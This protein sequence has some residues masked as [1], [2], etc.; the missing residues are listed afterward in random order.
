MTQILWQLKQT[1]GRLWVRASLFCAIAI[2][3]A[4]LAVYFKDYIPDDFSQKI[5]AD[6]VDGIL[7]IIAS[8]MLAVTTFSLS[9]MVAAYSAATTNVTPRATRLLLQDRTSQNSLSTFIGAFIFALV[10]IVALK[11][12]VY[13][14]SGRLI[15]FVVTIL[16]IAFI[17]LTLIR[18]IEY[19]SRLGRVSETIN[20]IERVATKATLDRIAN[21]YLGGKCLKGS[22]PDTATPLYL[23]KIGYLQLI[24]MQ[25]LQNIATNEGGHIYI[26]FLPGSFVTPDRPAAYLD[27]VDLEKH[28]DRLLGAFVVADDRSFDQDPRFGMIV[29]SEIASR[30]LSPAINDPGT[31]IEIIGTSVRILSLWCTKE[32]PD[33]YEIRYDRIYVPPITARD[34]FEDIYQPIARDGAA[35]M[36]VN[37]RLQKA[38]HSLYAI[39]DEDFKGACLDL[40]D[41]ALAKAKAAV[42]VEEDYKTLEKIVGSLRG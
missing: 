2:A 19:L 20:L 33:D 7:N 35:M 40:S 11:M 38:L 29:L 23:K 15:L 4:L 10:G 13:G 16:V 41:R 5:G 42:S 27:G 24:D 22:A 36:E 26:D 14:D 18:W 8:S 31:A 12:G 30:A 34:L 25:A 37:I 1:L 17:I 28:R 3:T 21:P 6:A 39:G 9:T 32:K